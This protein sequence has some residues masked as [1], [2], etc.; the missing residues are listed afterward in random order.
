MAETRCRHGRT[1][2]CSYCAARIRADHYWAMLRWQAELRRK[3]K[4]R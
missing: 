3:G 2:S 1:G 4:H